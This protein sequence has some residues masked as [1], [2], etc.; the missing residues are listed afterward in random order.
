MSDKVWLKPPGD[1]K[2]VEV[3]ATSEKLVPLMVQGYVQVA[4]PA[5]VKPPAPAPAPRVEVA[6]HE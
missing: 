5:E 3:E 2:P 6:P 1:G 4:G